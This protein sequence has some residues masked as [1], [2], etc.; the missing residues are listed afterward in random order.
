MTDIFQPVDVTNDEPVTFEALVGEGKK[1]KTSDDLAKAKAESDRFI[2]RLQK[3]AEELR[4]EVASK[5]TIDEVLTRVRE[6]SNPPQ[7]QQPPVTPPVNLDTGSNE[8]I[9]SVVAKL[10]EQRKSED[11]IRSNTDAVQTVLQEKFGADAQIHLN[12]KAQEL[13]VSLDYLRRIASESPKA[14][15]SLIGVSE[16][17]QVSQPVAAPRALGQ[18]QPQGV[19]SNGTRNKS[20]YDSIKAK[21]PTE[22]FSSK[23]Q[24]Q[25]YKDAMTMGESFYT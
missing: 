2:Q 3:E 11:R 10:L 8:N 5:Q 22:Y 23:T 17:R 4:R 13:N 1:F 25:M 6:M 19:N 7:V 20:Y 21:N 12:K 24:N 14:F 9:E 16:E 18:V 15:F